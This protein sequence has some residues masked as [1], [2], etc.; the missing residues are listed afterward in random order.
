MKLDH[1]NIA[2]P[3]DLLDRVRDFY[4]DVLG[5]E[6]GARPGFTRPGY[7]LYSEDKAC[8]HLIK[9]DAHF[10]S[11]RQPYLDHIAF[12]AVGLAEIKARLDLHGVRYRIGHIA[13]NE[14]TQL[15]L[16]DPAGT[17][18]EINFVGESV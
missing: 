9:S 2:A 7:W 8:V 6:L 5:F 1:Y 18:I 17:G 3:M 13:E 15:F 14:V 4:V 16:E 11:E 12:R 10:P